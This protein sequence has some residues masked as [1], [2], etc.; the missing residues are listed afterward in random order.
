MLRR[1]V[2]WTRIVHE[3]NDNG[4]STPVI[5]KLLRVDRTT[6]I[7]WRLSEREPSYNNGHNLL[8]LWHKEVGGNPLNPPV[9]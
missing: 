1:R 6:V 4:K 2:D 9:L 5:A 7:K 3:I 8:L